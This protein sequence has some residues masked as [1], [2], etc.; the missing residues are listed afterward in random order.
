MSFLH[1]RCFR[2]Q[3]FYF[4][5]NFYNFFCL[6]CVSCPLSPWL[7]DFNCIP[8]HF[9]CNRSHSSQGYRLNLAPSS[10]TVP[11]FFSNWLSTM[12]VRFQVFW[13]IVFFLLSYLPFFIHFSNY[14]QF[15]TH[16][17]LDSQW[18]YNFGS[19]DLFYNKVSICHNFSE[20]RDVLI[21]SR[22]L[23]CLEVQLAP[24][25][26]KTKSSRP[27]D[28]QSEATVSCFLRGYMSFGDQKT[29]YF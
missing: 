21:T 3:Y 23:F 8:Q 27:L 7:F 22:N 4:I 20:T 9:I 25:A 14:F 15:Y 12:I 26:S 29:A 13:G 6:F 2:F 1:F 5:S 17:Q 18:Y 24:S 10:M 11:I 16:L 28:G 19:M